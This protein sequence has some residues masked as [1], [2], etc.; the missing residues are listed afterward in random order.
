VLAAVSEVQSDSPHQLLTNVSPVPCWVQEFEVRFEAPPGRRW[1][2]GL[3]PRTGVRDEA[4]PGEDLIPRHHLVAAADPLYPRR[5]ISER[6]IDAGL[7][8]MGRFEHVRVRRE[9]E[10]LGFS[11]LT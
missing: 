6:C 11:F 2:Q 8:Q 4:D 3:E 9:N 10:R 5:T 1:S 7:P